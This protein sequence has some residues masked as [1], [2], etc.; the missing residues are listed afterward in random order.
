MTPPRS[1]LEPSIF[2]MPWKTVFHGMENE[3][4]FFPRRGKRRL[5]FSTLWKHVFHAV[6]IAGA[7]GVLATL[8]SCANLPAAGEGAGPAWRQAEAETGPPPPSPP[9]EG[10][11]WDDLAR[12]AADRSGETR[13][14]RLEADALRHQIHAATAWPM[15]QVR[16]SASQGDADDTRHDPLPRSAASRTSDAYGVGLRI[17]LPHPFT[18]SA[19][20]RSGTAAAHVREAEARESA[21]S[22]FF[23]TRALCLEAA[24]LAD[25]IVLL[26]KASAIRDRIRDIRRRQ[27]EAGLADAMELIQS[28]ARAASAR[29]D[30]R[31]KQADHR[32]L[33]RA[34]ARRT[35]VPVSDLHLRGPAAEAVPDIAA[36]SP[37]SLL[38]QAQARRPEFARL[39]YEAEAAAHDFRAARAS[40]IPWFD[41]IEGVYREEATRITTR[42]DG[43]PPQD[44]TDRDAAEWQLRVALSLPLW[45]G[46]RDLM[47]AAELRRA[48]AEVRLRELRT[49]LGDELAALHAEALCALAEADR[50]NAEHPQVLRLMESRLAGL[51]DEPAV[52][53]EEL[54]ATREAVVAYALVRLRAERRARRLLTVIEALVG[55]LLHDSEP[56]LGHPVP[57]GAPLLMESPDAFVY[58]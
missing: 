23:E 1:R 24:F 57:S 43:L 29:E 31:E 22:A 36:W 39:H 52:R 9:P 33:L 27:A 25:E 16:L 26:E 45:G 48:A 34:I 40:A 38:R 10:Y 2:S 19:L 4:L 5:V 21:A 28:V 56:S 20:R 12:R 54:L 58:E 7:A 30:L 18:M 55:G 46:R 6:E 47:R 42:G 17:P 53:Q 13:A 51:A 11:A 35:G 14:R 15:P 44:R 8:A 37:Q 49:N 50:M 3:G 32:R 41:H